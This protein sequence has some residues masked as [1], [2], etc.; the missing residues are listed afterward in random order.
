MKSST[1]R[2]ASLKRQL[3]RQLQKPQR[4]RRSR[5]SRKQQQHSK[6]QSSHRRPLFNFSRSPSSVSSPPFRA[7]APHSTSQKQQHSQSIR[8]RQQ[9]PPS[10]NRQQQHYEHIARFVPLKL[11]NEVVTD[12]FAQK[13]CSA[14][15][16]EFIQ[17]LV[18]RA[19]NIPTTLMHISNMYPQYRTRTQNT[20]PFFVNAAENILSTYYV[21]VRFRVSPADQR[22]YPPLHILL[23]DFYEETKQYMRTFTEHLE[24]ADNLISVPH[25]LKQAYILQVF[26]DLQL[27]EHCLKLSAF[28]LYIMH[29]QQQQEKYTLQMNLSYH[30][31]GALTAKHLQQDPIFSNKPLP[32]FLDTVREAISI[33]E[34]RLRAA[35]PARNPQECFG[36][37]SERFRGV[38]TILE[39]VITSPIT[40]RIKFMLQIYTL[41]YADFSAFQLTTL[42][43]RVLHAVVSQR[44][45]FWP[46][47]LAVT[48]IVCR[49]TILHEKVSLAGAEHVD[50]QR[51]RAVELPYLRYHSARIV[52]NSSTE[53]DYVLN[54]EEEELD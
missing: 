42:Q 1:R 23:D 41:H 54:E 31:I 24:D 9:P 46:N 12:V 6:H 40:H 13:R 8:I 51:L 48:P 7:A 20:F 26:R 29:C 36:L 22:V 50:E 17:Q 11:T 4:P 49:I 2:R 16:F 53:V 35:R 30:T 15:D 43:F 32:I 21:I 37:A 38:T 39:H 34:D 44:H 52:E 27:S 28:Y 10:R 25:W 47:L 5:T 33:F 18:T 19:D 45:V 3:K 14:T